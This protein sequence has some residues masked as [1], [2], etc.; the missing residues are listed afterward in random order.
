MKL[1]THKQNGFSLLELLTTL[2]IFSAIMTLL[3]NSIHQLSQQ[4][5]K[6]HARLSLRQ[7]ARIL[8]RVMKEDIIAAVYLKRFMEKNLD[9]T[10]DDRKSGIYGVDDT[11]NEV[12]ADKIHMHVN[13]F[14]KFHYGRPHT[15]DPEL[16]E[17][18]YYLEETN[19]PS[20]LFKLI[21]REE[22]Y[23]DNDITDGDR[24]IRHSLTDRIQTLN[25]VYFAKK[26]SESE[27]EWESTSLKKLPSAVKVQFSLQNK[28]GETKDVTF[29]VNLRPHMGNSVIWAEDE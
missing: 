18:S 3:L 17:V 27:D 4:N 20:T 25:I 22:L 28:E 10:T 2:A 1:N 19:P 24:S 8:E 21:R 5:E 15:E 9:N 23:L 12:A 14:S 29:Q 7:E 13:Q 26:S 16:Y 11:I 6:V